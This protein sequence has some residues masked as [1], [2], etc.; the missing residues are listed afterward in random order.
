MLGG[1]CAGLGRYFKLD[2]VFVRLGFVLL[3]IHGG[4]GP[5]IY[6]AL[7][8]VMPLETSVS[9]TESQIEIEIQEER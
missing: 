1:V 6:I 2:P 7:M 5:L 3:T 9:A 8:I 4:V